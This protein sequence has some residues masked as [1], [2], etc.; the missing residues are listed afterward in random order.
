MHDVLEHVDERVEQMRVHDRPNARNQRVGPLR[1]LQHPLVAFDLSVVIGVF[2]YAV[3]VAPTYGTEKPL[4][5][6]GWAGAFALGVMMIPVVVRSAEESMKLVPESLRQASYAL[7]A[8]RMQTTLR[9]ILPAALPA[10]VTGVFLAVGR[11]AGETAPLILTA[12]NSDYWPRSMARPR[13]FNAL[14]YR[15]AAR[16]RASKCVFVFHWKLRS[17]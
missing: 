10:I 3:L 9:V 4:G 14:S 6:S 17:K 7:G 2:A 12:G 8:N 1:T 11:I 15:R 5:F 13:S 16:I